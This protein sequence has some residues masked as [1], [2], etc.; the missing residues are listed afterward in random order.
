MPWAS[1]PPVRR[2]LN[3]GTPAIRSC[4]TRRGGSGA[5]CPALGFHALIPGPPAARTRSA[6]YPLW[7]ANRLGRHPEWTVTAGA[8]SSPSIGASLWWPFVT[9][10]CSALP[11]WSVTACSVFQAPAAGAEAVVLRPASSASAPF[12][13]PPPRAG[14]PALSWSRR[15]TG[16]GRS[17]R[18]RRP[19]AGLRV[20]A[21]GSIAWA[22][23]AERPLCTP[24]S[25]GSPW[26]SGRFTARPACRWAVS[27]DRSVSAARRSPRHGPCASLHLRPDDPLDDSSERA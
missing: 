16:P 27:G 7:G 13:G 21:T 11:Q 26:R 14:S 20:S 12:A 1:R 19:Q 4:R 10:T 8:G 24:T 6:L 15:S 2:R 18:G 3:C 5:R 25:P 17:G 22:G 23:R 9:S